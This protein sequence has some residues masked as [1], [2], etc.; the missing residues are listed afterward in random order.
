[1]GTNPEF[2]IIVS[3]RARQMLVSH[4]SFL[5]K[6]SP[7]ATRKT[8]DELLVAIRSLSQMPERFPYLEA[9]FIPV[10]KYHKMYVREWYLILYQI[11]NNIV[12]VDY[13]V[14]CRQDYRWLMR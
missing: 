13:I 8:K 3:D 5:A 6:K 4:V 14:D 11:R 1:M 2:E 7:S 12:Y 10:N 9:D